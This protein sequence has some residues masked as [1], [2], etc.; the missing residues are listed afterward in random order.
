[1]SHSPEFYYRVVLEGVPREKEDL[2]TLYCF[3]LG[4]SGVSENLPFKQSVHSYQ[5]R[6]VVTP[7]FDM[8]AYFEVEV[9]AAFFELVEEKLPQVKTKVFQEVNKDWMEEWK[10][11]FEAFELVDG[12][13]VVPS[14]LSVPDEAKVPLFIDPGMAFGTGTH[15]TTKI[16]AQ[17][18]QSTLK[19]GGLKQSL[20]DVGTGTGVL[21]ILARR[22][23]VEK[24]YAT[25]IDEAAREVAKE[26]VTKNQV[27]HIIVFDEQVE[28]LVDRCDLV[29]ANIIDGVLV[30][31]QDHLKRLCKPGGH[32]ILTGILKERENSFR[33]KFG[34]NDETLFIQKAR[35]EEDDWVGFCIQRKA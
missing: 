16:A 11:G 12:V 15:A 32:M 18:L 7:Y 34:L 8:Q 21:S 35:I 28:D 27:D 29:V 33:K 14:W 4:A 9:P 1:M 10:K 2:L 26:N 6:T 20:L 25:E 24:V 30:Q 19:E 3:E 31:L 17:L 22:L 23:G 5:P 13:W